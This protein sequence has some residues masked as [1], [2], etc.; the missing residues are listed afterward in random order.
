MGQHS[1]IHLH[2]KCIVFAEHLYCNYFASCPPP[3][4]PPWKIYIVYSWVLC[5]YLKQ[6]ICSTFEWTHGIK[7]TLSNWRVIEMD[8]WCFDI[9]QY[10]LVY[11]LK[12]TYISHLVTSVISCVSSSMK[13]FVW[14][15]K[16]LMG[17]HVVIS[18]HYD[19]VIV[20]YSI[21]H[22]GTWWFR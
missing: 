20:S 18:T 4:P 17:F 15:W 5:D 22:F 8:G 6:D 12:H 13:E 19:I 1:N 16:Q 9:F 11:K 2:N 21:T 14:T 7:I 10:V 3:P